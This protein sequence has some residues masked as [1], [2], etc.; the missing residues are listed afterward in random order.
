MNQ[1]IPA[2]EKTA[3]ITVFSLIY[4]QKYISQDYIYN[5]VIILHHMVD[6]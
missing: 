6:F 5:L 4:I 2:V 1:R 3:V